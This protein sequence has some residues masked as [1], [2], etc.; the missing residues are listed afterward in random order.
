MVK[1]LNKS[2]NLCTVHRFNS[3]IDRKIRKG[4]KSL[5]SKS[6][7]SIIETKD[8]PEKREHQDEDETNPTTFPV[9]SRSFCAGESV[10]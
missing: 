8:Y 4:G 5:D 3:D 2:R 10:K 6:N 9:I 7:N 1:N